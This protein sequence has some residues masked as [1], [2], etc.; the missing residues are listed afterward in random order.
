MP[1]S[2]AARSVISASV[3]SL[4]AATT[5]CSPLARA[6]S[7]TK[8]GKRPLPAIRPR[9]LEEDIERQFYRLIGEGNRELAASISGFLVPMPLR[10]LSTSPHLH[11]DPPPP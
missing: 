3:S 1:E 2:R 9:G 6:A 5:T 11:R 7:S 8:K 4:M 10:T